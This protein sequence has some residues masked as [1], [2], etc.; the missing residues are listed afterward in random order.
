MLGKILRRINSIF[1]DTILGLIIIIIKPKLGLIIITIVFCI[2]YAIAELLKYIA[3]ME[4]T[5]ILI[6]ILAIVLLMG[7]YMIGRSIS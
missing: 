5:T 1:S 2:G 7:A 6:I 4:D 3:T